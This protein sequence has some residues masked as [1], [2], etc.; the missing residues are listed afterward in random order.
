MYD[1]PTIS[2]TSQGCLWVTTFHVCFTEIEYQYEIRKIVTV[3]VLYVVIDGSCF[4]RPKPDSRWIDLMGIECRGTH[5]G[6]IPFADHRAD[7][8]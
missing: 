4:N 6:Y 1:L 8:Y 2:L 7:V 3:I 5:Y